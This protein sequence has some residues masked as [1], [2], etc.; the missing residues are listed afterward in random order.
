[1]TFIGIGKSIQDINIFFSPIMNSFKERCTYSFR[2]SLDIRKY[3]V[4][5]LNR[6]R[7]EKKAVVII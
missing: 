6:E 7:I 5:N 3:A 2:E 4:K 1:M